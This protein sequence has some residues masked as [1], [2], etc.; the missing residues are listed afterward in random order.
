MFPSLSRA[1]VR[2]AGEKPSLCKA[3]WCPIN[4]HLNGKQRL[5][6]ILFSFFL[7]WGWKQLLKVFVCLSHSVSQKEPRVDEPRQKV[8]EF[9]H[10]Q[11]LSELQ[12]ENIYCESLGGLWWSFTECKSSLTVNQ[13]D[14]SVCGAAH[15]LV[16][17]KNLNSNNAGC[18]EIQLF[19]FLKY[20]FLDFT[21]KSILNFKTLRK[22]QFIEEKIKLWLGNKTQNQKQMT[23][24]LLQC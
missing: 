24:E 15:W 11:H 8:T 14:S 20:F 3:L 12:P 10:W 23:K 21:W 4:I 1:D 18:C 2:S 16:C 5:T 6:T 13:S 17:K 22:F 7:L 9:N 19:S